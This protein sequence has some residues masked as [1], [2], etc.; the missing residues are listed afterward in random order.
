VWFIPPKINLVN[1]RRDRIRGSLNAYRREFMKELCVLPLAIE[2]TC[3]LDEELSERLGNEFS[4]QKDRPRLAAILFALRDLGSLNFHDRGRETWCYF[5]PDENSARVALH[6]RLNESEMMRSI[7]LSK[8]IM[9][10]LKQMWRGTAE[11]EGTRTDPSGNSQNSEFEM[12][13]FV[14]QLARWVDKEV[15]FRQPKFVAIDL[16][17]R[18]ARI[19]IELQKNDVATRRAAANRTEAKIIPVWATAAAIDLRIGGAQVSHNERFT[20]ARRANGALLDRFQKVVKRH[21]KRR[22]ASMLER[23][24]A[25]FELCNRGEIFATIDPDGHYMWELFDDKTDFAK[26]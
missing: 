8:R 13:P 12:D 24:E 22:L 11:S 3:A 6:I 25:F 14:S 10:T 5:L 9:P 23:Q 26:S 21:L 2:I 1:E 4:A 17:E 19:C 20:L 16:A 7:G 15:I 18:M